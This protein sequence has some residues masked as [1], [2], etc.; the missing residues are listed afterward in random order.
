MRKATYKIPKSAGDPED[1]EMSVTL[2]SGA[3]DANIAR[4]SG[5]F[6]DATTVRSERT[7]AGGLKVTIVEIHGALKGSATPMAG[8]PATDPK[9]GWALLGAIAENPGGMT[10]FK[11]TGPAKTVGAARPEFDSLVASLHVR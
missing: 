7:L 10:F 2:A 11:M 8:G 5:Q 9:K 1:A 6:D 4:W 3:L